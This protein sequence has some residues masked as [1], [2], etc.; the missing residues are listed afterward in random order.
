MRTQDAAVT[1][2]HGETKLIT[3]FCDVV[4]I[5]PPFKNPKNPKFKMFRKHED[6]AENLTTNCA[7]LTAFGTAS[8]VSQIL[9]FAS[10]DAADW[11]SLVTGKIRAR[12]IWLTFVKNCQ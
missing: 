7:S 3:V 12:C 5:G 10:W 4:R 2:C 8:S 11:P 1:R 6:R 9:L